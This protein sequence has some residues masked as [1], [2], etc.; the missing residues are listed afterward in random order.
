MKNAKP[1]HET[2]PDFLRTQGALLI[3]GHRL[4]EW[5]RIAGSSPFYLYDRRIIKQNVDKLRSALPSRINLHYAIKANPNPF[6]V[7]YLRDLVDGADVASLKEQLIAL[8][9][10]FKANTISIA[11]PGKSVSEIDS[12]I[13]GGITL[14]IESEFEL[15]KVISRS[16]QLSI[17]A[18]IALRVNPDYQLKS[19]GVL[20][21]GGSKPF[22]IDEKCIP[23]LLR[24]ISESNLDFMGFHIYPASQV[25]NAAFINQSYDYIFKM[26]SQFSAH[27]PSPLKHLNIGGGFGIP[28]FQGEKSLDIEAV[29][30]HLE[31]LI[32]NHEALLQ[33]TQ[34]IME[35]GR[36]LVGNAGLYVT[37]VVD[38]K[39]SNDKTFLI[40]NGGLHHNLANS[41]NFGQIIRKNYYLEGDKNASHISDNETETVTVCGPLCTP[42]DI[43]GDNVELK[44]LEAGDYVVVFNS[45]AYGL[46]ASPQAFLGQPEAKEILA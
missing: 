22:G 13:S 20:M 46:S 11:G 6:V 8:N 32:I 29:G 16:N 24:L 18:K 23:S 17:P 36:Y 34:I 27:L 14:H 35:F 3:G 43:L 31:E 37:K 19:A 10:G 2:P 4:S 45:G 30:K 25:L 40:V 7:S 15:N 41:G 5:E 9:A 33:D 39:I 26:L 1:A 21:G 12:A 44:T 38:K 42:L 28:Y